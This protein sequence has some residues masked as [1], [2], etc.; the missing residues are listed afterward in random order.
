MGFNV[1]F[2]NSGKV[3]EALFKAVDPTALQPK[4]SNIISVK[5]SSD[6]IVVGHSLEPLLCCE[7]LEAA[8]LKAKCNA[9]LDPRVM[10]HSIPVEYEKEQISKFLVSQNF[11]DLVEGDFTVMYVYPTGK[12]KFRSCVAQVKPAICDHLFRVE[13]VNIGWQ[14]C[15]F[16]DYISILQCF[17]C[18]Q[19]GHK[20]S[21]YS[22]AVTCKIYAGDHEY[23]ECTAN[24]TGCCANCKA[25]KLDHAHFITD[26]AKCPLLRLK[27]ERK[28]ARIDYV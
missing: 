6:V 8:G 4:V 19:F 5:D 12:K 23:N 28:V 16:V 10:I 17:K 13:K 27:I 15:R 7:S 26:K 2:A 25:N 9:K 3:K 20:A 14:W 21:E 22:D 18:F 24:A 1:K 11:P